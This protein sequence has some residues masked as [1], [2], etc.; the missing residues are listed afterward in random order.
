M[1][2][3][4]CRDAKTGA[5]VA[6]ELGYACGDVYTSL[7][8]F[9]KAPSAGTVQCAATAKRLQLSGYSLWDLGMELPYKLAMGAKS[10]PR[11]DFLKRLQKGRGRGPVP[12]AAATDSARALVD[13]A[14]P[15]SGQTSSGAPSTTSTS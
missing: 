12:I 7:S 14:V 1:H 15:A 8:G 3:F 13:A 10:M 2:T 4:E 11:L 5:L 9:S 6:G